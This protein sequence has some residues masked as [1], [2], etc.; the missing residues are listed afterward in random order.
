MATITMD[1]FLTEP[2]NIVLRNLLNDVKQGSEEPT[3]GQDV[4]EAKAALKSSTEE[5]QYSKQDEADISRLQ[6]FNDPQHPNFTPTVL[7][8]QKSLVSQE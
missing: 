8:I 5:H 4:L 1:P 6:A 3:G 7:S 2:D